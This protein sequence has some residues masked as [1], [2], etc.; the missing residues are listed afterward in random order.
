[1]AITGAKPGGFFEYDNVANEG[2][3]V[4]F[5]V[6][7]FGEP[8]L[9]KANSTKPV[10]PVDADVLVLT[11]SQA[12]MVA[13]GEEIIGAGITGTLRR[14]AIGD[15]VVCVM[16]WAKSEHGTDY[17][18][19]N[20]PTEAQLAQ[21]IDIFQRTNGDPYSAAE[22]AANPTGTLTAAQPTA[23]APVQTPPPAVI[24]QQQYAAPPV[25]QPAP[26]QQYAAPPVQAPQTVDPFAAPAPVAQPA[27]AG[28]PV[29]GATPVVGNTPP[30]GGAPDAP[31]AW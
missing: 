28:A 8:R 22:R 30:W 19:A 9:M 24:P 31:P 18:Q 13:R 21:A 17:V 15:D 16:G 14:A 5:K 7:G 3:L 2:A 10:K 29:N 4:V 27:M 25:Q 23:P 1:M 26:V 20:P 11:G 12:R 6:R